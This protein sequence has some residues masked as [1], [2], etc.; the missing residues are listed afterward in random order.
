MTYGDVAFA[1]A[2]VRG[3]HTALAAFKQWARASKSLEPHDERFIKALDIA[4]DAAKDWVRAKADELAR[5]AEREQRATNGALLTS[6]GTE[7]RHAA[8]PQ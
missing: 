8:K 4:A 6:K 3:V 2:V 1:Q 5:S 7:S